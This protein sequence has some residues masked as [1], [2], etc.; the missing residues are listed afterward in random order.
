MERFLDPSVHAFRSYTLRLLNGHFFS[1]AHRHQR[2]SLEALYGKVKRRPVIRCLLDTNFLYSVLELHENPS[3]DAAKALLQTIERARK[4]IDIRLYVFLPTIEE[5]KRSLASH[6]AV[7]SDVRPTQNI[8]IAASQARLSGVVKKFF[9]ESARSGC[10]ISVKDYFEPYHRGLREILKAKGIA[11]FN[12]KTEHYVKDQRLIDDAL[13]QKSFHARAQKINKRKGRGNR[14]Y[15]Q[16]WHDVLLWYFIFDRRPTNVESI[17]DADTLGITID[18]SLIGFDSFKRR[19]GIGGIP[20]V[21]HPATLIQVF[22]FFAPF[23][24][25]IEEAIIDALRLPLLA[26]AFDADA[27]K[28]TLRILAKLSRYE[29]IDDL[30]PETIRKLLESE[31]LQDKLESPGSGEADIELIR[32]ALIE[33]AARS[34]VE[35]AEAKR[36]EEELRSSA[37]ALP[38]V[39][40]EL[41]AERREMEEMRVRMEAL[42]QSEEEARKR[43]EQARRE[44]KEE[45]ERQ[46]CISAELEDAKRALA[47]EREAEKLRRDRKIF[48]AVSLFLLVGFVG[49]VVGVWWITYG[50]SMEGIEGVALGCPH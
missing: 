8:S 37:E 4:Y 23:D 21:I 46:A 48:A 33:H 38:A 17:V 35:L 47:K 29:N 34:E 2:E 49:A 36:R 40:A 42:T 39:Q 24:E 30:Q 50:R 5:F 15:E 19:T 25:N 14:T 43:A 13:D 22:Q 27:E 11:L 3:N 9:T 1:L 7:L 28:T 6:E 31:I 44:T 18:Y 16:I 26:Q 20:V 45:R 32:E 12:E 41:L 10:T